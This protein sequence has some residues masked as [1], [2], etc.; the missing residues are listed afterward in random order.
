[1]AGE[2]DKAEELLE[3]GVLL[4]RHSGDMT[5]VMSSLQNLSVVYGKRG[6]FKRTRTLLVEAAE[7]GKE[8]HV[9]FMAAA[10]LVV[11]GD[12]CV[13]DQDPDAAERAYRAAL[14]EATRGTTRGM[15]APAGRHYAA[16][17]Q[18]QGKHFAAALILTACASIRQSWDTAI[19]FEPVATVDQML[20]AARRALGDVEFARAVGA[21][22]SLATEEA[23]LAAIAASGAQP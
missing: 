5:A 22:E 14:E 2:L 17:L 21:G 1:L 11:F 12:A 7:L 9:R 6:E 4:G 23:I 19:Y 13:A 3:E 8:L 10:S 18:A 16:L 15:M 20:E